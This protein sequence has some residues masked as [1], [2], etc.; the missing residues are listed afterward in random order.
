MLSETKAK[1]AKHPES[2]IHLKKQNALLQ[3]CEERV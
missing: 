1:K 2:A 3:F